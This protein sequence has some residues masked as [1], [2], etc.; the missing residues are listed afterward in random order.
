MFSFIAVCLL[1]CSVAFIISLSIFSFIFS[2]EIWAQLPL[3]LHGIHSTRIPSPWVYYPPIRL[4]DIVAC[5]D[6]IAIMDGGRELQHQ[7]LI[8][9]SEVNDRR[10]TP[11]PMAAAET[12]TYYWL[13]VMCRQYIRWGRGITMDCIAYA[14]DSR[15]RSWLLCYFGGLNSYES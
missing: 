10:W 2:N 13:G 4:C 9:S 6:L 15:R 14:A 5:S 8:M 11:F 7:L 12:T 3:H 1:L